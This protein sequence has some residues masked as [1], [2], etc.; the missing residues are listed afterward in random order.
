MFTKAES[1]IN[2]HSHLINHGSIVIM[3]KQL[4]CQ[5]KGKEKVLFSYINRFECELHLRICR[6][7]NFKPCI[8][9]YLWWLC[10]IITYVVMA[11]QIQSGTN[12][13]NFKNFQH[14]QCLLRRCLDRLDDLNGFSVA[15]FCKFQYS[16]WN[17]LFF[18]NCLHIFFH[19]TI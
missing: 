6:H 12:A 4:K 10:W 9:N 18:V 14:W 13:S 5:S 16:F 19:E 7:Q 3:N 1:Y 17:T 15:E 11:V 8:L 2:Q